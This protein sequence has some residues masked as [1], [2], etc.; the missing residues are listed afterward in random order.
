MKKL[1]QSKKGEDMLVDFWVIIIWAILVLLIFLFFMFTKKQSTLN[2][3]DDFKDKDATYIL[4]AFV[5]SPWLP[6]NSKSISGIIIEDTL[7]DPSFKNTQ[8][9]LYYFFSGFDCYKGQNINSITLT[10]R[11]GSN[12]LE[13]VL[14]VNSA[15]RKVDCH[16]SPDSREQPGEY[17]AKVTLPSVDS[18]SIAVEIVI[19]TI[20][21][22]YKIGEAVLK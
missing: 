4:N 8:A 7:S 16:P 22:K 20:Y 10:V 12:E 9:L 5:S 14:T 17:F 3:I 19:K 2:T 21:D 15:D 11:G 13:K 6:D 1:S 18:K